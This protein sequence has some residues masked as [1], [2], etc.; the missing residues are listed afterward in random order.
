MKKFL[1][2]ALLDPESE[3]IRYIGKSC[4]GLARPK[5]HFYPSSLRVHSY[6][7]SWMKSVFSRGL[8]P[9][10]RVLQEFDSK[11]H[12]AAA[13]MYFISGYKRI[14]S[15]LTN[16]TDG[17]GGVVNPSPISRAKMS[18]AKLGKKRQPISDETRRRLS[19]SVRQSRTQE[20]RLRASAWKGGC[21]IQEIST[22]R[23]FPTVR[24]ASRVLGLDP[25]SIS[26]VLAGERPH[27]KGYTFRKAAI[28]VT[29]RS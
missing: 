2:Y 22:G 20:Y 28:P 24:E 7:N 8:R 1:I 10:I 5:Q 9:G 6:K 27:S 21:P 4:N 17:G 19:E 15:R 12:L 29:P 3:E 14:G 11:T 25:G 23:I 18:A 13:E 26:K 16:L